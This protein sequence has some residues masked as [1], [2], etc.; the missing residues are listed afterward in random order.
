V[1]FGLGEGAGLRAGG[2]GSP[3]TEMEAAVK[4]EDRRTTGGGQFRTTGDG[5]GS[6]EEG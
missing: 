4:G 2:W 6:R 3:A 5:G 1:N